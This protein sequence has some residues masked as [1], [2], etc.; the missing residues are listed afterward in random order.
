MK[1]L[2]N[3][4]DTTTAYSTEYKSKLKSAF[5]WFSEKG[6]TFTEHGLNRVVS[7]KKGKSKRAITFEDVLNVLMQPVNYQDGD[8][9]YIKYY[10]GFAAVQAIDTGEII[11]FVDRSHKINESWTTYG[12]NK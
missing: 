1:E 8:K 10:N 3:K 4:I 9:K 11:S 5:I 7:P 6:F 2:F 12:N